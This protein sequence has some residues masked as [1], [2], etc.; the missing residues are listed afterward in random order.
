MKGL[1]R[2]YYFRSGGS[3][4]GI[5][6]IRRLCK[7]GQSHRGPKVAGLA[8]RPTGELDVSLPGRRA[9]TQRPGEGHP[10]RSDT[11]PQT[12][13]CP[14]PSGPDLPGL[15][16]N[17]GRRPV[18]PALSERREGRT[19][20]RIP[21]ILKA[22][23]LINPGETHTHSLSTPHSP[24]Q[25]PNRDLLRDPAPVGFKTPSTLR[26]TASKSSLLKFRL[27]PR[28]QLSF[29]GCPLPHHSS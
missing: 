3:S 25:L 12:V 26:S 29:T 24:S 23:C 9:L 1:W 16:A 7:P 14:I 17:C 15:S 10:G 13:S 19:R 4:S 20:R 28:P 22:L 18:E 5:L 21:G 6:L 2:R 27:S 11:K 8:L